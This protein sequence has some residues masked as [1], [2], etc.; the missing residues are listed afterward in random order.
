MSARL[1]QAIEQ[2]QAD[3]PVREALNRALRQLTDAKATRQELVDAVYRAA[4]D[5]ALTMKPP[6]VRKP[7]VS[8]STASPEVAICLLADWQIGKVTPAYNS[9][10]AI[11]R[12]DRYAEK[13]VRLIELQRSHHPVNEARIYLLGD[14][15]EGEEIF[16][17]Q[18]HRIDASL[19]SQLFR[20]AETLA[21]LVRTIAGSVPSVSVKGVI[22]NH[23]ALGGPIRRSYHPESNADAMLYNIARMMVEAEPRIAWEETRT[24]GER[25]WFATDDVLGKRWFIAHMD[26]IKS[27]SFGIPW[28]GFQKR[29][30]GWATSVSDFQYAAGGHWHVPVRMQVNA[31]TYWGAGSTESANTYAQEFLASG[32]QEPSQWLLFQGADGV[33]AE[34][35]VRL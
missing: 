29:L 2:E 23:G 9:D 17:G 33:T 34:W 27:A 10:T 4:R 28:Y 12:I 7:K 3:L 11:E 15:V 18:A 21:R 22:G 31:I 19:Y 25:A 1:S 32:G 13:V 24:A 14:L 6:P 8:R 5:A 26:Q 16:P 30:L 20:G 35:L